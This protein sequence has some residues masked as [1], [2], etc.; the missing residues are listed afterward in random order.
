MAFTQQNFEVEASFQDNGGEVVSRRYGVVEGTTYADLLTALPATMAT[1]A[2]TSDCLL[3]SYAVRTI[4]TNDTITLPASGVQNENQALITA[5]IL[6]NPL[7]SATLSIPGAKVGVFVGTSGENAN[8]VNMGASV[9]TDFIG[10]FESGGLLTVSD[11][12]NIIPQGAKGKRRHTKNS[13][14]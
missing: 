4:F 9:V 1:I 14:G 12:E 2:A 5:K 10:L 6:G 11:G 3:R 7:K 13:N 8:I